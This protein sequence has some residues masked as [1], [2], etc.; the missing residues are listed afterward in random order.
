MHA[1]V[2]RALEFDRVRE[3]LADVALTPLGRAR[4]LDLDAG[5]RPGRGRSPSG[6]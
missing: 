3:A 2:F 1:A 4:A 6:A 5:H